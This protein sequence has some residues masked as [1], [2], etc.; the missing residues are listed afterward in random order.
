[1]GAWLRGRE[2]GEGKWAG[3]CFGGRGYVE[4]AWFGPVGETLVGGVAS[5][6]G[7]WFGPVGVALLKGR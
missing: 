7:A 3:L 4:G 2:C 5:R 6:K 1:M